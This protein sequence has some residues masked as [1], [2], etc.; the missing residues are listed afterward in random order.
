MVAAGGPPIVPGDGGPRMTRTTKHAQAALP[1][2][3]SFSPGSSMSPHRAP[4]P[5]PPL[6][7]PDDDSGA[8]APGRH[9]ERQPV[10]GGAGAD[11]PRELRALG[12]PRALAGGVEVLSR[13]RKELSLLAYVAASRRPVTRER[14]ATLLWGDRRDERARHSLRQTLHRLTTALPDA[15]EVTPDRVSVAAAGLAYDA[16]AFEADVSAGRWEDAVARWHGELLAGCDDAGGDEFQAWLAAER[17]RLGRLHA[18]ALQRLAES[19]LAEGRWGD[20]ALWAGRW[21]DAA[22]RDAAAA[23]AWIEALRLSGRAEEAAARHAEISA[24]WTDDSVEPSPEWRA[25]GEAL[26]RD[27]RAPTAAPSSEVGS[28]ALF[29]PD[30]VGRAAHFAALT[31]A[32]GRVRAGGSSVVLVEG[33]PGV[34]KTRLCAD[35]A[36]RVR[37]EGDAWLAVARASDARDAGAWAVLRD[38]LAGLERAPG[39][40]GAPDWALAETARLVPALRERFRT[41]AAPDGAEELLHEAICRVLADVAA[42]SPILLHVD[43]SGEADPASTR[44]LAAVAR[45]RIP[46]VMLLLAAYPG[47]VALP[48]AVRIAL[49]PLSAAETETLVAGMLELSGDERQRLGGWIHRESEGNPSAAVELVRTLADEGRLRRAADGTWRL[50]SLPADGATEPVRAT[51]ADA[52]FVARERELEQLEAALSRAVAGAGCVRW[53]AGEAGIG[54]TSLLREFARRT[55]LREPRAR[56][57]W[58]E[59]DALAGEGAAY[60]PFREIWRALREAVPGASGSFEAPGAGSVEEWFTAQVRRAAVHTPLVL[61]IDD[62]QWADASSLGLLFHLARRI[63]DAAV[64]LVA[65][66]RDADVA[67]RAPGTGPSPASVVGEWQRL[68]GAGGMGLDVLDGPDALRLAGEVLETDP[69]A[70]SPGLRERLLRHTGGHP[71]FLVEAVHEL[72]AHGGIAPTDEGGWR[73][74][75]PSAWTAL[76]ARVEGVIAERVR[77]LSPE[78]RRLLSVAAVEGQVFTAEVL[79]EVAG[80]DVREVV[81]ELG[82]ELDRTHRLVAHHAVRRLPGGSESR[83][84]FR[85]ALFQAHT[86][87]LLDA[88]ERRYLHGD[89]GRALERLY[90]ERWAEA[91]PRLARHFTEA[92]DDDRAARPLHAAGTRGALASAHGEAAALFARARDAAE[93]SGQA[94]L[95]AAIDESAADSLHLAG[96]HAAARAAYEALLAAADG[97]GTRARLL[98]KLGDAWQA[99]RSLEP[100]LAAYA[101]ARDALFEAPAWEGG[102]FGEWARLQVGWAQA[103]LGSGRLGQLKAFVRGAA[104]GVERYGTPGQRTFVLAALLRELSRREHVFALDA[105]VG[106]FRTHAAEA[107]GAG[108]PREQA[109]AEFALGFTQ[110]WR[111]RLDEAEPRLEAALALAESGGE[112][113]RVVVCCTYL[114][115]LH[116]RRGAEDEVRRWTGRALAAGEELPATTGMAR[117]N[118]A[119]LAG[120]AGDTAAARASAAAAMRVWAGVSPVY[121]F[122]WA[123]R[124]P[125]LAAALAEDAVGEA[126]EHARAQLDPE[127]QPLP[128]EV[129]RELALAVDRWE[130]GDLPRTR[131]HLQ[132]AAEA[133]VPLGLL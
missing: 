91:A 100:A 70:L 120:R 80:L 126:V 68:F 56:V 128:D 49:A 69:A 46:G 12:E 7:T 97:A 47:A 59:C 11:V 98:R 111:G 65:A 36:A 78:L 43:D 79:A 26:A 9:P 72:R 4:V 3:P 119:W 104:E 40:G 20:A 105:L 37:G 63:A 21:A 13:R 99:E 16:S 110:L 133:A 34:G 112:R 33:E 31:S 85:H 51:P 101:R 8:A 84:R 23:S 19:A 118:E 95:R 28:A 6:P 76:P 50:D 41:L 24:R 87:G 131:A 38:A 10:A 113:W 102:D 77:R 35:F 116:R 115:L 2:A 129:A 124:W 15:L 17:A 117:A 106:A 83:Y 29:G 1:I 122:E 73:E 107:L 62:L 55:A 75:A 32:W 82:A 30:L 52:R 54:K 53:I 81:R 92:G 103:L 57:A 71:L 42:E 127:Q 22:P 108:K 58:G 93:R 14:L 88:A 96:S 39:I 64:L 114:A 89:V 66:Y 27:R 25:L 45:R 86:Y 121:P 109:G 48:G 94:G 123:A 18:A 90:G 74:G 5:S 130:S 125:L 132:G 44:L 60:L 61:V 67:A